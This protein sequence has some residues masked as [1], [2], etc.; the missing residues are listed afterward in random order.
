MYSLFIDTHSAKII[1]VLYK[2]GKVFCNE[3]LDTN[4]KHSVATFPLIKKV[5]D[6]N[7]LTVNDI[8]EILVV[9]GPGSFTGVRI[10]VTIAKT[11]A[12]SLKVPIKAIDSL[13]ILAINTP[14]KDDKYVAIP[15]RNGAFVGLFNKDNKDINYSY[16]SKSDYEL[17]CSNN[18]VFEEDKVQIDYEKVYDYLNSENAMNPH[19]VNPLYVKGLSV[20]HDK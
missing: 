15:D 11:M 4:N 9:N 10:A 3:T 8:S 20:G 18:E 12:Y 16:Y 13:K 19:F 14:S 1:V 2:D 17:L 6:E 7:S 5:F